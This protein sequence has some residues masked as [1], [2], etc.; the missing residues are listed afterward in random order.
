[1]GPPQ[2]RRL[3]GGEQQTE[4]ERGRD[5][6]RERQSERER[7]RGREGRREREKREREKKEER[8]RAR[9]GKQAHPPHRASHIIGVVFRAPQHTRRD[10]TKE[11]AEK[12]REEEECLATVP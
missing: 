12:A 4:R 5:G 3:Q 8:C 9:R 10:K 6:R 2:R 1:M 11:E 7:E